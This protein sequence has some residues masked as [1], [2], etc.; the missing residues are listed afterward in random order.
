MH[1][2]NLG[3]IGVTTTDPE[4][5]CRFATD[6]LGMMKVQHD[7]ERLLRMDDY[8]WRIAVAAGE[9]DD[10]AF[11]GFELPGKSELDSLVQHLAD[12]GVV[13]TKADPALVTARRVTELYQCKD[14][15]GL[16]IE[17]Y[18][19][20]LQRT[21][22]PF[23]SPC[24]ARFITGAQGL[25]H[26]VLSAVDIGAQRKFYRDGLGLKLSDIMALRSGQVEVEFY[27]CN[28]RHHTVA[29]VPLATPN[30]LHH[31]MVEVT[32]LDGV[33]FARDRLDE[34]GDGKIL[35]DVGRHSN[36]KVISFY[37][38]MP[39]GLIVEYG[40]GGIL[41]DDAT[42]RVMRYEKASDWGHKG[43]TTLVGATHPSGETG[44]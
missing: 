15:D 2:S 33:G 42:W 16:P 19:G 41:V 26:I 14:P 1:V 39:G 17:L 21:E 7:A 4:N 30:R 24:N 10:I 32:E 3:Y 25:G 27:H 36:D 6:V 29:L 37:A 11:A 34:A 20:A 23:R 5:W 12:S 9:K 31:F 44:R 40:H 13:V 8:A 18:Y 35:R 28:A 22:T 43:Q 38:R